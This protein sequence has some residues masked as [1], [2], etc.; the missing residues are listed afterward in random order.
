MLEI[1]AEATVSGMRPAASTR[2]ALV[3]M[4]FALAD[5]PS[6]QCGLLKA[7]LVRAG[8]EADVHYLN[9]DMAS[10]LGPD[11]YTQIAG[12]S[13]TLFLGEWLFTAAAFDARDD[14]QAY[15]DVC[16]EIT[17][18]CDK[19]GLG[20][21]DICALRNE[22]IP[23]LVTAWAD[24]TDW[25]MYRAVGFTSM[26]EQNVA[27]LALA[28]QIKNRHPEVAIIFGG[29]NFDGDMGPEYVRAFP[30]IDYAVIGEGDEVLPRL[31]DCIASGRSAEGMKGVTCRRGDEVVDGGPA[32]KV[33]RMDDLP[34]PDFDEY[35]TALYRIGREKVLGLSPPLLLFESARGC[36]WGQ[37]HHCTFCGLNNNGMT[38]RS[39]SP[40]RVAQELRRLS[41]RYSI[42]NFAAVDN[43]MDMSYLDK[44]CLSFIDDRIDYSIFYEVKANLTRSQLHTLSRAGITAIQP[45]IE[46]LSSHILSLMRKGST[47]MVNLRLLKWAHYYGIRVSWNFLTGFPG[48]RPEDYVAQ[49]RL[50]PLLAHLPPPVGCGPIW[51]ERFSPYFFEKGSPVRDVQAKQAYS[52]IYPDTLDLERIAYYFDYTMEGALPHE[53]SADLRA[54]VER[55]KNLWKEEPHPLLVYQR[56][57]DWIQIIDRRD[58]NEPRAYSFSGIEALVYELCSD[59]ARTPGAIAR[60]LQEKFAVALGEAKVEAMLR[61]FCEMGLAVEE[62]SRVLGLALPVN[63]NW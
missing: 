17:S 1:C 9:L 19:I 35:F 23:E 37:K 45:G 34:E 28:R 2:I 63:P 42:A 13:S 59:S 25:S 11:T 39:K 51:L 44:L 40:E 22:K 55:W 52:I 53:E 38:F 62:D 31:L 33:L 29:A 50:L 41:S 46:S 61:T 4:P 7:G 16:P 36:W 49:A 18:F 32:P 20:F 14:E 6:I 12:L 43:I 58:P 8:Y 15:L 47:M 48:E 27:A 10:V 54:A 3:N 26:F 5:R 21:E 56:A 24:D 57:P 60:D 30:W